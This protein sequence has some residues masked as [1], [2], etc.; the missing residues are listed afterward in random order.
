MNQATTSRSLAPF[1]AYDTMEPRPAATPRSTTC[2]VEPT[3]AQLLPRQGWV[4]FNC[5]PCGSGSATAKPEDSLCPRGRNECRTP[6][7][8]CRRLRRP[9]SWMLSPLLLLPPLHLVAFPPY[10]WTTRFHEQG[11]P[12]QR[13]GDYVRRWRQWLRAGLQG[14]VTTGL[15]LAF[16]ACDAGAPG[17]RPPD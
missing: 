9:A 15:G 7:V 5:T 2:T 1:I 3:R 14:Y 16:L 13:I 4:Q 8:E 10:H 6:N 17:R 11:A 12:P